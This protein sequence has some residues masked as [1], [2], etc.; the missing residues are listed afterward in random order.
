MVA[1]TGAALVVAASRAGAPQVVVA[2][3]GA[4]AVAAL[5][6]PS[7]ANRWAAGAAGERATARALVGV[8]D[9]GYTVLHDV[10]LPGRRWNLDHVLLGPAGVVIVE[11]KQWRTPI[12]V[13][14][15]W[16]R[17][18]EEHVGWQID[19]VVADLGAHGHH[20][21]TVHGFV[22]VHGAP[23]RR[24]WWTGARNAPI[25]DARHLRRWLR[26][27]PKGVEPDRKV[28]ESWV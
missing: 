15:R 19:A 20:D 16:P 13:R 12:R 11:S 18:V 8:A 25:G 24:S 4:L 3:V 22:C 1:G 14:R 21:T 6:W 10:R 5:L 17:A 28:F 23:V 26:R 27:L 9:E 2:A 7:R